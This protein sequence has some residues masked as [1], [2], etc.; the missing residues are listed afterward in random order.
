MWR[1]EPVLSHLAAYLPVR[2]VDVS[3]T[4]S[5]DN[6]N[7][8][9]GKRLSGRDVYIRLDPMSVEW[10]YA[11]PDGTCYRRQKAEELTAERIRG[12][13]VSNHRVRGR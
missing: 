5:L 9:V 7:R 1:L 2:R 13:E 3:G 4:I 8:Y 6:R 11:G 10:V 12:L